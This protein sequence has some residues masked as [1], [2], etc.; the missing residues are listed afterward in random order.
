MNNLWVEYFGNGCEHL[1]TLTVRSVGVERTVCE[2]C[3]N[4]S[5][6]IATNLM[7]SDE[8]IPHH[9]HGVE[10]SKVAGL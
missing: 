7:P 10:L 6:S 9:E 1:H 8:L 2:D 5:F 4:V 3:R